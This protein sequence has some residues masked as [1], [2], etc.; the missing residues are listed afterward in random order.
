MGL[1]RYYL[2]LLKIKNWKHCC[3][4]IFK[5]VNSVVW[6]IFNEKVAKKWS[7]WDLWTMHGCTVHRRIVKSCGLKKK[8]GKCANRKA[9]THNMDRNPTYIRKLQLDGSKYLSSTKSQKKWIYWRQKHLDGSRSS[10]RFYSRRNL[11]TSMNR[12]SI[13]ICREKEKEELNR[14]ESIEDL[15]RSCRAWKKWVFQ[16]REKHIEMNATSKDRKSVV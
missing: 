5:C 15:S 13:K 9:Q 3:K 12:D 10:Q 8:K 14:R 6:P 7:L 4:I 16:R 11:E 1:F 2:F